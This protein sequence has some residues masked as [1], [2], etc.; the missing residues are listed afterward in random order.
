M[1]GP[2]RMWVGVGQWGWKWVNVRDCIRNGDERVQWWIWVT[3]GRCSWICEIVWVK[4]NVFKWHSLTFKKLQEDTMMICIGGGWGR[5]DMG[6]CDG[7]CGWVRV[8]EWVWVDVGE[9]YLLGVPR[10]T[11]TTM[12][13]STMRMT[14][15]AIRIPRQFRCGGAVP[16]NSWNRTKQR[17]C[18]SKKKNHYR[19]R[20]RVFYSQRQY[21]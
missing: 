13:E 11:A 19:N 9:L 5:G 14:R 4:V 10:M 6:E 18:K 1:G 3:M 20:K 2:E 7:E 16:T 17:H 15:R 21:C 12:R 8:S